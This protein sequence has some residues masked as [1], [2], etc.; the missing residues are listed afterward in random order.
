MRAKLIV[1]PT[2]GRAASAARLRRIERVLTEKGFCLETFT[3]VQPGEARHL[4]CSARDGSFQM[5]ICAGGDGTIHEVINGI[6]GSDLILGILP[7]GTG[8]VLAWEMEIPLDPLRACEVLTRGK[9]KTIDLGLTSVGR[10]FSCMAGV[11]LDAQVVRE[12]DPTVKGFLGM[13]AYPIA[14]VRAVIHYGLPELTIDIDGQKPSLSGYSMVVCNSRHY[15]GRFTLCPDAA[16]DDGWL[17]VC[18]LQKRYA[19]VILRSG[20]SVLLNTHRALEGITFHRGQSVN[21][22][23]AHKVLVQS[24]GDIIGT[25]PIGFSIAPRALKVMAP[26]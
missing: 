15:G 5:V 25:T 22:S 6:A 19:S 2:S 1:N 26:A 11:G 10:Y 13:F 8:N 9:V 7:M 16:I 23:S 21:V 3:A 12:V 24:D 14:A 4:A 17:N 20:L 18:I